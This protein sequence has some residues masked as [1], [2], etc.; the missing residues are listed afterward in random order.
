[1]AVES[2]SLQNIANEIYEKI[3]SFDHIGPYGFSICFIGRYVGR[4]IRLCGF[5]DGIHP[6]EGCVEDKYIL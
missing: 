2:L 1:M 3:I 4:R 5:V 6:S